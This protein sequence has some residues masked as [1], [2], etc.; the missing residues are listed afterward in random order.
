MP[1]GFLRSLMG[2]SLGHVIGRIFGAGCIKE[3]IANVA[4]PYFTVI[5]A[6][7]LTLSFA[8][9]YLA[10]VDWIYDPLYLLLSCIFIATLAAERGGITKAMQIV[11][12]KISQLSTP[13]YFTHP[14]VITLLNHIRGGEVSCFG[15][16]IVV[17]IAAAIYSVLFQSLVNSVRRRMTI[18]K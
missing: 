6:T 11:P 8:I 5:Q 17:I 7:A 10:P 1:I 12:Y 4:E 13:L 18:R 3:Y 16:L 15:D 9:M 2:F 14:L